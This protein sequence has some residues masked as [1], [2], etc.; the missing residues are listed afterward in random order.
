MT[1][2]CRQRSA[3]L[4]RSSSALPSLN[5]TTSLQLRAAGLRG[6]QISL[7]VAGRLGGRDGI[8]H[9]RGRIQG[10]RI[11]GEIVTGTRAPERMGWTAVRQ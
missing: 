8:H 10:N 6:E 4:R 9:M 5:E 1:T 11:E 3:G 2:I 7:V